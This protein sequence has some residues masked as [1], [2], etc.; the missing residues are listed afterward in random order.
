M[1]ARIPT[2][3]LK[4][5]FQKDSTVFTSGNSQAIRIP[6]DFQFKTKQVTVI[7][8]GEDLI[9]MPKYSD[10]AEIM[11]NLPPLTQQEAQEL[12][13]A[14]LT[15]KQ[16]PLP[17]EQRDWSWLQDDDAPK[18]STKSSKSKPKIGGRA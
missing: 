2:A 1:N 9:I 13:Q 16:R 5:A 6:K 12:D 7:Q 11:A 3:L 17:M 15:A 14:M 18:K 4:T 10:W 8:R